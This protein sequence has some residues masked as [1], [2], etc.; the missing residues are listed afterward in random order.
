[1]TEKQLLGVYERLTSDERAEMEGLTWRECLLK[2][3]RWI[4]D[5]KVTLVREI[6]SERVEYI[7]VVDTSGQQVFVEMEKQQ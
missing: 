7:G 3:M 1:M 4:A 5:G 2:I 6:D